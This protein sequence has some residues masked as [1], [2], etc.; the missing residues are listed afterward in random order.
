MN[1][2][3]KQ[4]AWVFLATSLLGCAQ[5]NLPCVAFPKVPTGPLPGI[6]GKVQQ[7]GHPAGG[8][9]PKRIS[10]FVI[11]LGSGLHGF[12]SIEI[13]DSGFVTLILDDPIKKHHF[14]RA[15]SIHPVSGVAGLLASE[16]LTQCIKLGKFYTDGLSDGTQAF[17]CVQDGYVK[18]FT[19]CDNVFPNGFQ[20][21]WRSV[22]AF[23]E[24]QPRSTWRAHGNADPFRHYIESKAD[25]Q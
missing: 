9:E 24:R 12:T 16:S 20:R 6:L 25:S 14:I 19:Y 5:H 1:H 11:G 10:K 18:R 15:T 8:V 4:S 3:I 17:L 22:C 2:F 21:A 7:T 13:R 23:I